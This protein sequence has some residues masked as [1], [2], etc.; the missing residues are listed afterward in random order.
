M[1]VGAV[2]AACCRAYGGRAVGDDTFIYLQY[3]RNALGGHGYTFNAG[4]P[5]FGVTSPAWLFL[6]T[7]IAAVF[8]NTIEVWRIASSTLFAL[9]AA[10][11]HR[12]ARRIGVSP[13]W[14]IALALSGALEPHTFRWAS[15]GMENGL[16]AFGVVI[17]VTAFVKL[18]TDESGPLTTGALGVSAGLLPFVRP[19]LAVLS[20]LLLWPHRR[21]AVWVVGAGVACLAAAL[22]IAAFGHLVPQTAAAKAIALRQLDPLYGAKQAL[23]VLLTGAGA[24]VL[25]LVVTG[26]DDRSKLALAAAASTVVSIGYL[27]VVNQL[28]S[29]RYA[30]YLCYPLVVTSLM[31]SMPRWGQALVHRF[32][33]AQAALALAMLVYLFPATRSS[34]TDDIRRFAEQIGATTQPG[35]RVAAAEVGALGFYADRYLIDLVGLV[36][37]D[38]LEWLT[39]HGQARTFESLEALLDYRQARYFVDS[40]AGPTPI[41]GHRFTFVPM[42]EGLV[43]RNIYSRGAIDPDRWRLYRLDPGARPAPATQGHS[44]AGGR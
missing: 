33:G 35:D 20:A 4:E 29:T 31:L 13:A 24:A 27:A 26:R 15:S 28:V 9:A 8:G 21:P 10:L 12:A 5:S 7:P 34:E 36:D 16:A 37:R 41:V 14:S 32:V 19:E 40:F 44:E 38:S 22:T 18:R 42:T 1:A 6:M 23:T 25:F 39:S 43:Y 2:V 11:L 30:S 3:V 17:A